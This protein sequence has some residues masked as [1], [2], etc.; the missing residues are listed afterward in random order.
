MEDLEGSAPTWHMIGH[1][2][3]RKA[4]LVIAHFDIVHSIDRISIAARLNSLAEQAGRIIPVLLEC[5][6]SGESSKYGYAVAGWE[7]SNEI[8]RH[9][10]EE[11]IEILKLRALK[12]QGLM[13]MPPLVTDPEDV[14]S[15]FVSLRLLRDVLGEQFPNVDFQQLSMGMSNDYEVA[16]E[17]GATMVRIG[18]AIFGEREN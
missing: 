17:E 14:R 7:H 12:I 16:V 2:Q 5:N 13:T 6:V 9:F 8:L 18:R 1:I 15:F 3:R 10:F 4:P 11:V